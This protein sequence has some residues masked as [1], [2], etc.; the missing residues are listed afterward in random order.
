MQ[1]TWA[2]SLGEKD[3]LEKEMANHFSVFMPGGFHGLRSLAIHGF[4]ESDTIE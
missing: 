1:E 2:Q 3:P 4:P